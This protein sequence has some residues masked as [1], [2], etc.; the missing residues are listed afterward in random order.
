MKRPGD[1]RKRR[2]SEEPTIPAAISRA[3]VDQY[4]G[5]AISEA[6]RRRRINIVQYIAKM[7]EGQPVKFAVQTDSDNGESTLDELSKTQMNEL[8]KSC[9]VAHW[10]PGDTLGAK[11]AASRTGTELWSQLA[12]I[13]LAMAACEMVLASWF[14]RTK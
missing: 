13:V 11:V 10:S 14:S 2:L 6:E 9:N 8:G 4:S 3:T 7:P 12:W 5:V 1:S